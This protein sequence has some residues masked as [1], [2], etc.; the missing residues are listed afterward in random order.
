MIIDAFIAPLKK[1]FELAAYR[2]LNIIGMGIG[3][4]G[5]LD[6]EQGIVLIEGVDKYESLYGVNLKKEFHRRLSLADNFT[7]DFEID[8]W[9]FA[10]GESWRGNARGYNRVLALTLGSGLGSAFIANGKLLADGP[11]VPPPYGWIGS[12]PYKDGKMDDTFSRRG[13]LALYRSLSTMPSSKSIDVK[14]IADKARNGDEVCRQVFS[15]F[16]NNLGHAL[17]PTIREFE[18]ECVVFG[19]QISRAFELFEPALRKAL[20]DIT[21]L[22]KIT[23]ARSINLSAIRGAAYRIFQKKGLYSKAY[24]LS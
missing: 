23:L 19:G 16:G 10:S 17:K 7:I 11:G 24:Y 2:C 15:S 13:I 4:C 18:A 1:N 3:M 21:H 8:T 22:R 9:D 14:D 6:Y 12:L 20:A 5:P